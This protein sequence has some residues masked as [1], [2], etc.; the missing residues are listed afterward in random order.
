MA[1]WLDRAV[2]YE[3]YPQSFAD[4]NGDGIGDFRGIEG[5]LDYLEDLGVNAVWMNPCFDSSFY[6]A[7]YDV[8][9]YYST[10]PRY[11]S[12]E[13]LRRLMEAFHQRGMHILL[14]LVPGH[15]AI[16]HPWFL[17]SGK[18]E[19]N[20]YTDRYIWRTGSYRNPVYPG[21]AFNCF[22]SAAPNQLYL[23]VDPDPARPNAAAQDRDSDS[24][25]NLVRR[26]IRFRGEHRALDS[27]APFRFLTDGRGYPLVYERGMGKEVLGKASTTF[28]VTFSGTF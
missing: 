13:D 10:A 20:A 17:E 3:I 19:K 9:D 14:D 16:D 21:T 24:L 22:S 4:S 25:L 11:G 12:N 18:D 23:P 8:R 28:S 27:P 15:T 1:S 26:L 5:K 7:G 6:D 2:F